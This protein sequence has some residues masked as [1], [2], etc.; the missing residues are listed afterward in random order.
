[1][2]VFRKMDKVYLNLLLMRWGK[3]ILLLAVFFLVL[4]FGFNAT[5]ASVQ[6]AFCVSCHEMKPEFATFKASA[7]SDFTCTVCHT[8]YTVGQVLLRNKKKV[9]NEVVAHFK[10]SYILPIEAKNKIPNSVC[11]SCHSQSRTLTPRGDLNL[12]NVKHFEHVSKG[13]TCVTC[14]PG[15]AHGTIAERQATIGTDFNSWDENKGLQNMQWQYVTIGMSQCLDCHKTMSVS[16]DCATCHIKIVLPASHKTPTWVKEGIHGQEAYKN[17]DNCKKC[18]SKTQTFNSLQLNDP[19]AEYARTNTFCFSC[20]LKKPEAHNQ[21]WGWKHGSKALENT[22]YCLV[23]HQQG[24]AQK[25]ANANQ[26]TCLTCHN[27]KHRIP[28]V[29]PVPIPQGTR[30]AGS[31]YTCHSPNKCSVCHK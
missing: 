18:H 24:A 8:D 23:C 28:S 13:I 20:H 1:M 31:C 4:V 30:P 17:I 26:I 15:I 7:H 22:K 2:S 6:T 14:H 11:E 25:N 5:P 19:I 10:K 16:Q 29:H 21:D 27:N 9:L 12:S 3:R